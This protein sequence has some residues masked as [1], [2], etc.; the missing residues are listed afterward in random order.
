MFNV[1]TL[2][3]VTYFKVNVLIQ[4]QHKE[5]LPLAICMKLR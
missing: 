3:Y 1:Y 5:G 2:I 4:E